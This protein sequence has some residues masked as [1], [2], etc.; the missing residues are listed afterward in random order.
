MKCN[1]NKP[2]ACFNCLYPDCVDTTPSSSKEETAFLNGIFVTPERRE[3]FQ[4]YYAELSERQKE[5]KRKASRKWYRKHAKELT[6]KR[7]AYH[8]EYYLKRKAAAN[9]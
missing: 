8:H 1:L 6:E 5:K 3:Y 2:Q 7:R 4:K 9:A